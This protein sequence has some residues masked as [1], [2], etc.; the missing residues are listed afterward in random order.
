[1]AGFNR[2]DWENLNI[3]KEEVENIS[4][5]LKKEE[6]RKLLSE[7]AEEITDP[8]NRKQYQ[9]E[10]IQ[11]EAQRGVDC[12]F[13]NPEPGFVVKT[14]VDGKKKAYINICKNK[15]VGR[16]ECKPQ[17]KDNNRGM[18]WS[19]PMCQSPGREDFD[20]KRKRCVIYDVVFHPDTLYLAERN[21]EFKQ[22]VID[23]AL[24]AVE[25]S[26]K[27]S[28][29][30]KNIKFPKVNFKGVPFATVI[31]KMSKKPPTITKED[32][33]FYEKIKCPLNPPKESD[34]VVRNFD[35]VK[36]EPGKYTIPKYV[37][38]QRS[39]I[40]LQDYTYD[41]NA[42]INAAI[43][44]DLVIEVNLPL[45]NSSKNVTLDVMEKSLHLICDK[46]SK[47]KLD[48]QL[49]YSVNE[50]TGNAKF[51]KDR[52][53]LI[54]TLPV[55]KAR[56]AIKDLIREDSG[57][58][59]DFSPVG[60]VSN[61]DFDNIENK[62]L[63]IISDSFPD[64][65]EVED[66]VVDKC[67][68]E[69]E[70]SEQEKLYRTKNEI[71]KFL[72][73]DKNYIL[74]S[75]SCNVDGDKICFVLNVKNI[76]SESVLEKSLNSYS[77]HIKFC[78]I[79]SGFFPVYY[80]FLIDFKN[81]YNIKNFEFTTWDNNMTILIEVEQNNDVLTKYYVGIDEDSLCEHSLD[82]PLQLKKLMH[83][84]ISNDSE[85]YENDNCHSKVNV[86][87]ANINEVVISVIPEE[88]EYSDDQFETEDEEIKAIK[89]QVT[90]EKVPPV[91]EKIRT[92]S[93]SHVDEIMVSFKIKLLSYAKEGKMCIC[94]S[95]CNTSGIWTF[96]GKYV[97]I[98]KS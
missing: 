57:V 12:T 40:D 72:D 62:N 10:I 85:D 38:K 2:N 25:D 89:T 98:P 24:N 45:L 63:E 16:P 55:V 71:Q 19:I 14:S 33:E 97:Y 87:T 70:E 1:M 36:K 28:L 84:I 93:E 79:G 21:Q 68:V 51:D 66:I 22:V 44:K 60:S 73:S 7:Y 92:F 23:T 67:E 50:E 53:M 26:F 90:I 4:Q 52:K 94:Y 88:S 81:E 58:E 17:Y 59:S 83:E 82:H 47:Y 96:T 91:E 8:K 41:R 11:L 86:K 42:K 76:D 65:K 34:P 74:P 29:D 20:K 27:V 80:A 5:A 13:V 61:N 54:I 32:A 18:G 31:R 48:I 6:F 43:P 35:S 56:M 9:D 75:F 37:I 77:H 49:P 78:S 64:V 39:D 95:K 46:P 3:T 15:A 69:C 30:K